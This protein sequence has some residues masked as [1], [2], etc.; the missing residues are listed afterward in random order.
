MPLSRPPGL[1]QALLPRSVVYSIS[2]R[3]VLRHHKRRDA[4]VWVA[5]VG[6]AVAPV[7]LAAPSTNRCPHEA[8]TV[9]I[10]PQVHISHDQK[11]QEEPPAGAT[12]IAAAVAA[13]TLA[14][15][16]VVVAPLQ[17]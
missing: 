4:R 12:A 3:I 13:D 6:G 16:A 11:F 7:T 8:Q 5:P 10:D 14:V 2:S 1:E 17:V 9:D 15:S